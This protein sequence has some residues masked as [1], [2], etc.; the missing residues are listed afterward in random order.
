MNGT[1]LELIKAIEKHAFPLG[2]AMQDYDQII[3]AAKDKQ[4]VLIGEATHGTKEFYK[5]RAEITQRLIEELSF[6]AVA[7]EADWPDAYTVNRYVSSPHLN[8][9]AEA[10]LGD[11]ERFPTWMW[12]NEEVLKFIEWLYAYNHEYHLSNPTETRM[13]GFYGLDLYS[14]NTSIHAVIDYLDKV[15]PMAARRARIRYS[16]LDHFMSD[17]HSY[18]YATELK[19]IKSCE[20]EIVEQ[21]ME[22][23]NKSY[24]HMK[25]NGLVAADEHFCATQNAKL[26]LHAED[27]YR[28]I[29]RGR[30][31]SWNVRDRHMFETLE[32]LAEYLSNKLEK[33][34]K[35]VVWAHNSHIGNA[36][37]TEMSKHG[38]LNIGHITRH[39]YSD[40][41]LLIGFSTCRGTV[42]AASEWGGPFERKKI[43]EPFAGSYEEVFNQVNYKQFLINLME[44]N[45]ATDLLI[46]PRLQRAI[47]VIYRPDTERH[48]HY[49]YSCLPEQFDFILHYDDTNAVKPLETKIHKHYGE[50]E[51]TYPSGL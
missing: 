38:E 34:A 30:P 18:G 15:D 12:R 26:V 47:G 37:A 36:A 19:L 8:I 32:N 51:E 22:L 1:E 21:L 4:F 3:D 20:N 5:S 7:V 13:V 6:D 50:L 46:E 49:F 29:F 33:N 48:S 44:N 14:M 2:G 11:F 43:S 31:D 25:V 17:P 10:A 16:C 24:D 9:T 23:R 42:T 39:H 45:E 41:S 27:Y 35:I 40:K 28:S